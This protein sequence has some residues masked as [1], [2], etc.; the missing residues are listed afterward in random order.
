[1]TSS[2]RH[3]SRHHDPAEDCRLQRRLSSTRVIDLINCCGMALVA[4]EVGER[5]NSTRLS[6]L[7]AVR[8]YSLLFR[9]LVFCWPAVIFFKGVSIAME[10]VGRLSLPPFSTPHSV[11]PGFQV[12]QHINRIQQS[13][14]PLSVVYRQ[15]HKTGPRISWYG[16]L[17]Y[18][19][20]R[21]LPVSSVHSLPKSANRETQHNGRCLGLRR[22]AQQWSLDRRREHGSEPAHGPLYGVAGLRRAEWHLQVR[23]VLVC[24]P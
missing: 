5:V 22:G 16:S 18:P 11:R 7:T 12:H 1:M 17:G 9:S 3:P 21:H 19:A 10:G 13:E 24:V 4:L 23:P 14:V 2:D 20:L 6:I 15:R 8:T